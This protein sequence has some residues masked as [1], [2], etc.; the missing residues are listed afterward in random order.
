MYVAWLQRQDVET[1]GAFWRRRL[2]GLS[3][4]TP[5]VAA[6]RLPTDV[7]DEEK[8]ED[9][10][11]FLS[12]DGVVRLQALARRY[13]VTPNTFAQAA[14]A[15][16]LA[17]Y[18][19]ETDIMFGVTVSGRPAELPGVEFNLG[20]FINALPLRVTVDLKRIAAVVPTALACAELCDA[21]L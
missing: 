3:E 9:I 4:P 5:L 10:V 1:A 19:S 7:G 17:H 13:Q 14:L 16:L 12:E 21:R 6:K 15:L 20:L 11:R 18:T 8:V 2:Q